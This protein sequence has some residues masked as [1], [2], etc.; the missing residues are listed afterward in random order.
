MGRI[1]NFHWIK[2]QA[3]GGGTKGEEEYLVFWG[4]KK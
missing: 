4:G 2:K 1:S 3:Q